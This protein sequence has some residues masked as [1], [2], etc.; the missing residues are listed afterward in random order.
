MSGALLEAMARAIDTGGL[1]APTRI[2]WRGDVV[3]MR[4]PHGGVTP[5]ARYFDRHP[6]HLT[7][8]NPAA[9]DRLAVAAHLVGVLLHI[10]EDP[11]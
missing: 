2:E 4:V 3:R 10:E 5:W 1:P 8:R 11:L 9:V 6:V 7:G